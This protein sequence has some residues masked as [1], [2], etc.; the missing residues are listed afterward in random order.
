MSLVEGPPPEVSEA[1]YLVK[2]CGRLR[3]RA[4][5]AEQLVSQWKA[6]ALAAE[7]RALD[8]EARASGP[9]DAVLAAEARA[10]RSWNSAP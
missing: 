1:D 5:A 8:A 6:R 2:A 7:R 10:A 4:M 3:A 9:L